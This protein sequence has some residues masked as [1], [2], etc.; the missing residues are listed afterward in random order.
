MLCGLLL[1]AVLLAAL[2]RL[3]TAQAWYGWLTLLLL[4]LLAVVLDRTGAGFQWLWPTRPE[5]NPWLALAVPM[6]VFSSCGFLRCYF[7]VPQQSVAAKLLLSLQGL[8]LLWGYTLIWWLWLPAARWQ[9]QLSDLAGYLLLLTM[10]AGLLA[11][12]RQLRQQP[13]RALVLLLPLQLLLAATLCL[14]WPVSLAVEALPGLM[15]AVLCATMAAILLVRGLFHAVV[16]EK[17]EPR[18]TAQQQLLQR[19]RAAGSITAARVAA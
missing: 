5:L 2:F 13:S 17:T 19:N 1:F 16:S 15:S 3:V 7:A 8:A 11:A 9:N 14:M 4:A 18:P 10:A 6:L 12:A